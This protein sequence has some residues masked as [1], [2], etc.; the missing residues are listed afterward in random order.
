MRMWC[1]RVG[2]KRGHRHQANGRRHERQGPF[3]PDRFGAAA[4]VARR[5]GTVILAGR[6]ELLALRGEQPADLRSAVMTAFGVPA[7]WVVEAA[8]GARTGD[9]EPAP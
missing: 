5:S 8:A 2:E 1:C 6:A 7:G 9:V 4:W 3:L